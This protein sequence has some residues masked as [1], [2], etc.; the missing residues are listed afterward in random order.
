MAYKLI[1][2]DFTPHDVVAK[3]TGKAKYAEDFRAEGMVFCKLLSSPM[4]HALIKKIDAAEALKM[5]GVL[6]M[7]TADDVPQFPPPQTPIL[8]KDEVFYV[9]EPILAVAA[10]SET[11]AADA[12]EKIKIDFEQLPHVLDPLDSLYPGGPNARSNGN[13]AAAQINL[14]TVKWEA[15]DFRDDKSL[16]MGKPAEQ[17]SYGDLDAGFT[18]AKLI[19]EESFVTAGFSHHSMEPRSAMAYWQGGKCILHGSNQSHTGAV[20]NIARLIGI[21]PKDLVLVAENCG[22][23]FGSKIP[24]YPIMAVPAL[25]SKKLGRPVMMRVTRLEEYAIGSARPTFQGYAKLGFREDGRMTAADLY[26]VHEN[27]PH[28]GAGDFRSA[29]NALSML[30]QPMAMRWRAIPVL[31]NTPPRGPQRGPGEN[32]LVPAIEPM[33]DKAARQLG[34]DRVAI[35]RINAP[36]NDAK[37]GGDQGPVTSAFMKEALDKGAELFKWEE[38]KKHS[39]QRTG[40]KVIGVG[41]GQGYH[42]AGTNGFDGL[43]RITP[44]GKLHVHT[45]VGNLGTYSHS[46]TSRVAAEFLNYKWENVIIERGDSR[47]GLPWNSVQAG[48]LT[49]STESRTNYVAA[50]DAK[51]KLLDIAAQLLGGTPDDYDLGEERVVAKADAQKSITYAQAAKKAIELAGKYSGQTVP[52]DINPLTKDAV[53]VIAGTGLIGVAKDNLPRKGITPGLT[54]TFVE[55]ELD[56][57]TGKF[58]ILDMVSVADCGTVLHPTGLA[59]QIRGGNVMGIGLAHLERHVYDPKLGLPAAALLYQAKPP[60]YLDVPAEIGW[61]AVDKPD[62]QNPVGVK[63]VGE[64]PQGS[65]AA[66]ITT[67]I[68]D[69]LGGHLFN[70]TPVS[71]DMIVN[72]LAGR[73]QSHKPLQINSV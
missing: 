24:G 56:V 68:S 61:G 18:A 30:Y 55:I 64:P 58:K 67:A 16:P 39:G 34:I 49:A 44:D 2:K 73:P 35:R 43:V 20:P 33:I 32:Q 19:I 12:I 52:D 50:M 59:H 70:R 28:I 23:G 31:T 40:N 25:M 51:Q 5:K 7:L 9:G 8:A 4:P 15:G 71:T 10:E 41:V 60:S 45:G 47:F 72:A 21:E 26:I 11:I 27:G 29:G 46:A 48:S 6:G 57:E 3:V 69:A 62:P 37:I 17:W 36:D 22:G 38:K 1:G 63:G 53:Q 65:G 42:S 13:V 66:A 14:Q 54:T